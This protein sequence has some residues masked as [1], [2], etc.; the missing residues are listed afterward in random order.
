M[1]ANDPVASTVAELD[2]ILRKGKKS[3]SIPVRPVD[4]VYDNV[5]V[6]GE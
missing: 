2:E 6:G 4:E 5:F 1:A 3:I